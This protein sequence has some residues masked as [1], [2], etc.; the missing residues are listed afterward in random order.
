MDAGLITGE[1]NL[2]DGLMELAE[3]DVKNNI[4]KLVSLP[5]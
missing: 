5:Y 1:I 4:V 2:V 3:N